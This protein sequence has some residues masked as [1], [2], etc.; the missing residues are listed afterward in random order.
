MN[1]IRTNSGTL[2]D[3]AEKNRDKRALKD[4]RAIKDGINQRAN[5]KQRQLVDVIA[6]VADCQTKIVEADLCKKEI[7]FDGL[8]YIDSFRI[9]YFTKNN[10]FSRIFELIIE[11]SFT[12]ENTFET[13]M[14]LGISYQGRINASEVNFIP[15]S[16]NEAALHLAKRLNQ[17]DLISK[18]ILHLQAVDLKIRFS[19][20]SN[21]WTI[22]FATGKGSTVWALF[23]PMLMLVPFTEVDAIKLLELYQ[24]IIY[25]IKQF[26]G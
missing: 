6:Q 9:S 19:L 13:D 23:P 2:L 24:L 10:L 22:G 15:L 12:S 18:R 11:S 17:I 7:F 14:E 20:S 8:P 5:I 3:I 4:K 16:Q 26:V 25:E 1:L 21:T